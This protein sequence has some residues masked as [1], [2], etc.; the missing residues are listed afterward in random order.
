MAV[1]GNHG[2]GRSGEATVTGLVGQQVMEP[3][4][5]R[6][7]I[8]AL[9]MGVATG[10]IGEQRQTGQAAIGDHEIRCAAYLPHF[11]SS[12]PLPRGPV[13]RVGLLRVC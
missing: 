12:L 2:R 8:D 13:A 5:N 11:A 7:L 6:L 10:Q 3:S 4:P 9:L 1:H